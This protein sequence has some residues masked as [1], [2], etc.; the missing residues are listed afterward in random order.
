MKAFIRIM[1]LSGLAL[2]GGLGPVLAQPA[3][4]P[5]T[6]PAE[7]VKRQPL[8]DQLFE[9][10]KS[11][12]DAEEARGLERQITRR[13]GR[14]G[15]DTVDLLMTRAQEAARKR[16]FPLALEVLDR[17]I[18]LQPDWAEGWNQR[19]N[20]FFRMEDHQ[21]AALDVAEALKREPR[22]FGALAG[23]GQILKA[24]GLDKAALQALR[25]AQAIHPHLNGLKEQ[26]DR[27]SAANDGRDA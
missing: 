8:I 22:H 12:G 23:L 26:I 13:W 21:R 9:K 16:D 7:P 18:V 3:S 27:L 25:A 4:R 10:L 17:I 19:A 24:Q 1:L 20:V 14:S 11:A 15:S 6:A 5:V 2:S